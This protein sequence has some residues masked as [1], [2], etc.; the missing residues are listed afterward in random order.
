MF[1]FSVVAVAF[2]W[3]RQQ[4]SQS[5][6]VQIQIVLTFF[7][8]FEFPNSL[9][10]WF[11]D[12]VDTVLLGLDF[13]V[14]VRMS[15]CR[16]LM[17]EMQGCRLISHGHAVL[18]FIDEQHRE[19][20]CS[21]WYD[22]LGHFN[23]NS[24]NVIYVMYIICSIALLIKNSMRFIFLSSPHGISSGEIGISFHKILNISSVHNLWVTSI[25]GLETFL[26]SL[27]C[28]SISKN[29]RNNLICRSHS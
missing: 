4:V 6:V 2:E 10:V 17:D 21:K 19:L 9:W 23:E 18:L 15:S 20:S 25:S 12:L 24:D 28:L 11:Y 29:S 5:L 22:T 8:Y 13:Q 16:G 14:R 3:I 1:F 26:M 27:A 7:F